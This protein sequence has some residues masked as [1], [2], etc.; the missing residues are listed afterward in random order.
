MLIITIIEK[1]GTPDL[2]ECYF[3]HNKRTKNKTLIKTPIHYPPLNSDQGHGGGGW[4][5]TGVY[6]RGQFP[7]GAL[8]PPLNADLKALVL[9]SGLSSPVGG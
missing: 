6:P 7:C 1:M 2:T 8:Q 3:Q 9:S 4:R 5:G